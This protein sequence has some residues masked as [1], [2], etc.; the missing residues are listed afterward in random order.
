LDGLM[1][2]ILCGR[3]TTGSIAI[4]GTQVVV[5]VKGRQNNANVPSRRT[6]KHVLGGIKSLGKLW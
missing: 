6:S 2:F 4:V 1:N 3:N 5:I